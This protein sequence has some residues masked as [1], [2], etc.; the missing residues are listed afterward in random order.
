MKKH[1]EVNI[2]KVKL[3]PFAVIVHF[4]IGIFS[5]LLIS[6]FLSF[7]ILNEIIPIS[8]INFLSCIPVSFGVCLTCIILSKNSRKILLS[9]FIYGTIY[10]LILYLIG[11]LLYFRFLPEQ[12]Y[13]NILFSCFI[14]SLFGAISSVFFKR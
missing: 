8:K 4:I 13:L 11:C 6:F 5:C 7:L 12:F 14:G 1:N 2:T 9:S 10:F 3:F